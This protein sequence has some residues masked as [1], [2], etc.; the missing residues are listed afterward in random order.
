VTKSTG[1]T[2]K[3]VERCALGLGHGAFVDLVC[4]LLARGCGVRF[5]AKGGSMFPTFRE[6]EAITVAPVKP[7]GVRLGDI[8]LCRV[9]FS[10]IAHRVVRVKRVGEGRVFI[11]RGDASLT[12]DEPVEASAVLGRV[13]AVERGGRTVH[14]TGRQARLA[15]A[16]RSAAAHLYRWVRARFAP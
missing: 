11:T 16:V 6:G 15:G 4:D 14:L 13:V 3:P 2:S 5:R 10:V 8:V 12:S 1:H 7:G 9:G